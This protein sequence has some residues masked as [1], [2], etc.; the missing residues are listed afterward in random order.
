MEIPR[1]AQQCAV[2]Q[3]PLQPG[4]TFYSMLLDEGEQF[5]RL[6]FCAEV[7]I[8]ERDKERDHRIGW[9]R[10]KV[11]LPTEKRLK[12]A[13]NDVLLQLFDQLIERSDR[14]EMCYVLT[15][16]LIRRRLLRIEK[17]EAGRLTVYCGKRDAIYEIPVL[18]P[19]GDQIEQTQ[20]YLA[21]LLYA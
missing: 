4:E 1:P 8:N 9:W 5:S 15:L 17:E 19:Q 18:L 11:P 13:P 20:E 2:T 6:D 7:W 12:L 16:L 10:A 14:R 21:E 3:R